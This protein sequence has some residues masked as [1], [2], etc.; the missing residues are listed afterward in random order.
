MGFELTGHGAQ[1]AEHRAQGAGHGARGTG[2]KKG[3]ARLQ[4][5]KTARQQLRVEKHLK[6]T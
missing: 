1:G 6:A 2:Q 3:T 4:D 5:R